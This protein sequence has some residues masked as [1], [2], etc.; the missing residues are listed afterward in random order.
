[1]FA[2]C[3]APWSA[4]RAEAAC[5]GASPTWT[6]TPDQTS[7][8]ACVANA[9]DGDTINVSAG[10]ATWSEVTI[11][12]KSVN[13]LGAGSSSVTING[14]SPVRLTNSGSRISGF[15]FNLG[16]GGSGFVIEG[17]IGWRIDHNRVTRPAADTFVLAYGQAGRAVEGLIDNNDITYGRVVYYGE[18]KGTGGGSGRWAE[19]LA[20]GS[21]KAIYIEDNTIRWLDGSS[22]GYLNHLDGNYGCRYV[23]R[24][25]NVIGGRF[26]A[27]ALQGNDERGCRLWE[28]YNNT[29]TNPSTP[30]YRPFLIRAGTGMIFHNTSDGRFLSN[31]IDFDNPRTAQP[32][33]I[34]QTSKIGACDG[35]SYADGNQGGGEGYPCRDQIGRSTD[36]SRWNYTN[37]APAQAFFPAYIWR[38]TMPSG[39]IPSRLNCI[40]SAAQCTRQST[41]HIVL[42]RDYFTYSASFNGTSGIGEGPLSSRPSTCTVGVGYWA[43]DQGEW[44]SRNGGPDGQLF[45]CSATNTWTVNYTPFA[46]PHPL[47]SGG[48]TTNPPPAAPGNVRIIR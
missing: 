43:T 21:S 26:E 42:N 14:G 8:N 35:T 41:K 13:L 17:S 36:A 37:P 9:R 19:P 5:T 39:E 38:N 48:S 28:I 20:I 29:L 16:S 24:F 40:G 1:M 32:D 10:T 30:G 25:N 6:S 4:G 44:N 23:A 15:T 27:H 12:G 46:Y 34:A 7:V 2:L 47:Q 33:V 3:L 45:R 18:D 22:S 31:T 11:S